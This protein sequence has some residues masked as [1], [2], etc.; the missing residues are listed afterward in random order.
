MPSSFVNVSCFEKM[1]LLM[2]RKTGRNVCENWPRPATAFGFMCCE[3]FLL[4]VSDPR[5]VICCQGW[6]LRYNESLY[7]P[8]EF[9]GSALPR[10]CDSFLS[11]LFQFLMICQALRFYL[12]S[13]SVTLFEWRISKYHVCINRSFSKIM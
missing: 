4:A 8:C 12:G 11:L 7:R 13:T 2:I 3:K 5:S 6:P 1:L 10:G 9:L